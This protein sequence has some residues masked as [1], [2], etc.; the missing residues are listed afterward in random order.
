MCVAVATLIYK[1]QKD[2][3]DIYT[4]VHTYSCPP[5]V[6]RA[7]PARGSFPLFASRPFERDSRATAVSLSTRGPPALYILYLCL[8]TYTRKFRCVREKIKIKQRVTSARAP[9]TK[10]ARQNYFQ[11]K[12]KKKRNLFCYFVFFFVVL[13][14]YKFHLFFKSSFRQFNIR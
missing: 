6:P 1:R 4:H 3:A 8:H 9:V 10:R 13:Q 11:K 14:L 12:K 2:S 5:L 7:A